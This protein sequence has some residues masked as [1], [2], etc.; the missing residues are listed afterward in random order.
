LAT[1]LQEVADLP[2][3]TSRLSTRQAG[4]RDLGALRR[5]LS[6]LPELEKMITAA[7]F[8]SGLGVL[9]KHLI[10]LTRTLSPLSDYLSRALADDLPIRLSDGRLIR[11]GFNAELDGLRRL[12]N[13][14][15]QVLLELENRER[16]ATGINTLRAGYNSIFGYYL[17]I[18]KAQSA[19]APAHYVRK[20]TLTNAERYITPELKEL[21]AKI[22]SAEE[23][24]LRLEATLF[25]EVRDTALAQQSALLSL[26]EILAELDVFLSLAAA[27]AAFDFVKPHVDMS[28][29]LDIVDGRHPV[30]ASLL[31]AGTIVPNHLRLNALDPQIV[32]LTGPNMSGKSTYL[33][34]TPTTVGMLASWLALF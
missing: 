3:V 33:N 26:A 2:R 10:D 7:A 11:A 5:S 15:D 32:I 13:E 21:E 24:M 31:P 14:S 25:E 6:R 18:T 34:P 28:Y 29:D 19:K 17:E 1:A 30:L 20:Q 23:K 8:T 12:K 27:A 4:P 16:S 22:L 9:G